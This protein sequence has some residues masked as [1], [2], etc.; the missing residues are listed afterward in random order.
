LAELYLSLA[1][2]LIKNPLKT[3][4][5]ANAE[6]I[7]VLSKGRCNMKD[8]TNTITN[9]KTMV[10]I[11]YTTALEGLSAPGLIPVTISFMTNPAA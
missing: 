6:A 10:G 2:D 3:V 5:A 9:A 4:P 11:Q 8:I 1:N 7:I